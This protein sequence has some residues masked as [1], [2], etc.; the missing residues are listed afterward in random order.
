MISAF[1]GDQDLCGRY[2]QCI[3]GMPSMHWGEGS[4]EVGVFNNTDVPPMH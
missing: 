1:G 4:S 2:L 3:G